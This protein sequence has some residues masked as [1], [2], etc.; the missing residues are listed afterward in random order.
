MPG[1]I[2][3]EGISTQQVQQGQSLEEKVKAIFQEGRSD[4]GDDEW[5]VIEDGILDL[6]GENTIEPLELTMNELVKYYDRNLIGGG[7]VGDP[8]L[9]KCKGVAG[10]II[11]ELGK[12]LDLKEIEGTD[13]NPAEFSSMLRTILMYKSTAMYL[14]VE[15]SGS[16]ASSILSSQL[17][18]EISSY[19][20][21]S[22]KILHWIMENY[23]LGQRKLQRIF[24]DLITI[25]DEI[26]TETGE[27]KETYQQFIEDLL[28]GNNGYPGHMI[29]P[30]LRCI[31]HMKSFFQKTEFAQSFGMKI[32][33]KVKK[34]GKMSQIE[35]GFLEN[36]IPEL[37]KYHRGNPEAGW[38][39]VII[40]CLG[41]EILNTEPYLDKFRYKE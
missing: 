11:K 40:Y 21:E 1:G 13:L 27:N 19:K 9:I 7:T 16:L 15:E 24:D 35:E 12:E 17:I 23:S 18:P 31:P 37:G 30:T 26:D 33:Q 28:E 5:Q 39:K 25:L 8:D 29:L 41:L 3:G 38:D 22:G 2:E 36:F 6:C 4:I 32:I 34:T 14:T 10:L 20:G